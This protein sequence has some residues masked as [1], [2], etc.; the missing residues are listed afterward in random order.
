VLLWDLCALLPRPSRLYSTMRNP[1]RFPPP[2]TIE[3]IGGCF[4]VKASNDRPLLFIYYR[5]GGTRRS[6]ARLLTRDA[7]QR[8]A[9]T[10]AK[11]PELFWES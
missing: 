8:I 2:W 1:R 4:V 3:D 10:I 5:D 9:V 7:A 11:L 6:L